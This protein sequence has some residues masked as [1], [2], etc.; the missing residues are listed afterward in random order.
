[1]RAP[2]V[3]LATA[4]LAAT[5]ASSAVAQVAAYNPSAENQE[6]LQPL[7]ADGTIQWGTFYKSAAIQKAYERLWNLGACR[8]TNKAIT[9]PVEH[10]KLSIDSLPEDEFRGVV[11]GVT[12]TNTGGAVAF[13]QTSN[14]GAGPMERVALLHPAG[15]SRVDVNGTAAVSLLAPGML[16][17]FQANVDGKGRASTPIQLLHVATPTAE[18]KPT[19]VTPGIDEMIVGKVVQLKRGMLS[20]RVDAG[21]IRRLT[22]PLAEDAVV[23]VATSQIGLVRPGDVI[24]IKGR[25]WTGEGALGDGTVFADSVTVTKTIN[26]SGKRSG[27]Q[28]DVGNLGVR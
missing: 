8:N 2:F 13:L 16:V 23:E 20:V 15:V 4:A 26:D 21:K 12:G 25:L 14:D 28:A 10:N 17:R 5:A 18:A 22:L 3:L 9:L 24:E 6:V 19:A 11:K 27:E 1:M 7:A